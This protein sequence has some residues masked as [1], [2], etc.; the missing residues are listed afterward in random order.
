LSARG[1]L[2]LWLAVVTPLGF[3]TKLY[4]GPGG[5]WVGD[6]AGG[7]LY[8][9]FWILVVMLVRPRL[10]PLRVAACVLAVTS[11]LETLQ[12]W[13]PPLLEAVRSSFLGHALLGSTFSALDFPHYVA[14]AMA[15]FAIARAAKR[16]Q[17]SGS[18]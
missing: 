6:H 4:R 9:V 3:G 11:L 14:G 10:E 17:K 16:D 8:V 15:G 13:S 5:A 2:A 18:V 12:L 7:V 1:R